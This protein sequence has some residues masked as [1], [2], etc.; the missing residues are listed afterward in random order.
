MDNLLH[1][2]VSVLNNGSLQELVSPTNKGKLRLAGVDINKE[3]N[4]AIMETVMALSMKPGGYFIGDV[5]AKMKKKVGD[6]YGEYTSAKAAYDIRK[7][8]GK[9]LVKKQ[10]G[11]RKYVTTPQGIETIVVVLALMQKQI[12]GVLATINRD[13]I[14]DHPKELSLFDSCCLNIRK[15]VKRINQIIGIKPAEKLSLTC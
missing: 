12:P 11:T 10:R 4:Q 3:Q 15:E 7:L 5:A 9:E 6:K 2:H 1:A 14:N 8:R 13:S